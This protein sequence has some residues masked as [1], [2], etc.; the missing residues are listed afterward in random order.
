V[1]ERSERWIP[2]AEAV[3]ARMKALGMHRKADLYR[4]TALSEPTV[5]PLITAELRDGT[6]PTDVT[7]AIVAEAL[8]W[9]P[10]SIDLLL[11]GERPIELEPGVPLRAVAQ[12][13]LASRL[14]EVADEVREL[15]QTVVRLATF[16]EDR[17][18]KFDAL[19]ATGLPA[20]IER[21]ERL[22]GRGR[23]RGAS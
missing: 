8:N 17:L 12:S 15:R 19:L 14:D 13:D 4:A 1:N 23:R 3:Q 16:S 2:V 9:T 7:C 21:I 10:E 11:A 18:P 22:E 5:R 20:L 6:D